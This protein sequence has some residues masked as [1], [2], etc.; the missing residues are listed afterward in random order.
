M[1]VPAYLASSF[2]YREDKGVTD[3]ADVIVA[4]RDELKNQQVP[5]WTEPVAGTFKSPPDANGRF[6]EF[7]IAAASTTRIN[8]VTRNDQGRQINDR[9]ADITAIDTV[10]YFTG[11][12]H[13]VIDF[14]NISVATTGEFIGCGVTELS[15]DSTADIMENTWM[16][17]RRNSAGTLDT[18]MDT[19][20]EFD[21]VDNG[22]VTAFRRGVV[23][24]TA[25]GTSTP[26]P[27]WSHTGRVITIPAGLTSTPK[28]APHTNRQPIGRVYQAILVDS[29]SF[30]PG[31]ELVVPID[32]AL[33]G[34]FKVSMRGLDTQLRL[35]WRMG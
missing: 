17:G 22:T 5:A 26:I 32:D 30:G 14:V 9:T 7:D 15:P 21:M 18:A 25:N 1:A 3:V 28:S 23:A 24:L 20:P 6:F 13:C 10:R 35:A 33:T 16:F 4:L 12:Y 29:N 31:D 8:M 19:W 34:K 27:L 2:S 11:Q